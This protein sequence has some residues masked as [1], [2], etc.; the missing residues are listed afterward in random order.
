MIQNQHKITSAYNLYN[1]SLYSGWIHTG[2]FFSENL[3]CEITPE[4]KAFSLPP[5]QFSWFTPRNSGPEAF[6]KKS[7]LQIFPKVTGKHLCK[8]SFLKTL[9]KK[10]LWYRC[11]PMNFAKFRRTPLFTENLRWLLDP[12]KNMEWLTIPG[13]FWQLPRWVFLLPLW[14]YSVLGVR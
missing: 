11:F 4:S 9:L 7:V 8:S 14:Y 6:C 1:P 10:R 5:R 3:I 12:G 2:K 13:E